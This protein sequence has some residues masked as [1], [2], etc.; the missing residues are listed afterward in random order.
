ML[1]VV[2]MVALGSLLGAATGWIVGL[3]FEKTILGIF[4]QIGIKDVEMWQLG[5]FFGFV[6]GFFR[7][8]VQK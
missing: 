3:M 6:G 5:V 7:T 8:V 2:A 4:G 1:L